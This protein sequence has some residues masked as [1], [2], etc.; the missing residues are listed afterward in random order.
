MFMPVTMQ[1]LD[2]PN[3]GKGSGQFFQPD[4]TKKRFSIVPQFVSEASLEPTDQLRQAVQ[5]G[6]PT[7]QRQFELLM[8]TRN[9]IQEGVNP[10]DGSTPRSFKLE[11]GYLISPTYSTMCHYR[12]GIG[13]YLCKASEYKALKR[14]PTCCTAERS[15]EKEQKE[16]QLMYAMILIEYEADPAT[17]NTLRV[18]PELQ[19][20][21]DDKGNKLDFRYSFRSWTLNDSK[22]REF[23]LL[24][25]QFPPIDSDYLCWIGKSGSFDKLFFQSAG[26]EKALWQRRGDLFR[27][28]II[29][30]AAPM[31]E[32]I[33]KPMWRDFSLDDID[34]MLL[35]SSA[36][37]AK[38]PATVERDFG[39]LIS[40]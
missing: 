2:D 35:G 34:K 21:L 38:R 19:R 29:E 31:W 40:N 20:I 30:E 4:K 1:V 24:H 15:D 23:K 6:D 25:G 10:P 22:M 16:P 17:G 27:D 33:P 9:L 13:F 26:R 37:P 5:N 8:R 14:V 36:A 32:A 18:I 12:A 28:Q 39:S 3:V 7:A 11:N